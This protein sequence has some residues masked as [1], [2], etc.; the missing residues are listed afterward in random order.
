M[1]FILRYRHQFIIT[2]I[3]LSLLVLFMFLSP[4]T[5]LSSGI[6][7]AYMSTIPFTAILALGLTLVIV[8]GEMDLSFPAVMAA[9]GFVFSIIFIE[10]GSVFLGFIAAILTGGVCGGLNAFLIVKIG[11]PSIIATIGTQFFIRGLT[12][13]LAQ[14]LAKSLIGIRDTFGYQILSGRIAGFIPMQFVWLIILTIIF[15][16]ILNNH[17]LG[18]RIKFTGDNS[19]AAKIMGI[20]VDKTK[21]Y[22]FIIMGLCSGFSGALVCCEMANWWPTQG[23]GFMLVVFASVFIGGT[24]VYGGKGTIYGTFVGSII[25]SMIEAGLVSAGAQGLW[26]RLVYG[27]VI[28]TAVSFYAKTSGKKSGQ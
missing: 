4:R 27:I 25:I 26:T 3:L 19:N 10:T 2:L 7:S 20:S 14:G 16:L 24:S 13:L 21:T 5:F 12:V 28:I 17:V 18:D 22:V 15:I 11:V 1:K 6:Y 8:C 23:E 9:S